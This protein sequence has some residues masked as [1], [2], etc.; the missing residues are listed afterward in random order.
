MSLQTFCR[1]VGHVATCRADM[2][3]HG[4]RCLLEICLR[5][6][7][8]CRVATCRRLSQLSSL[9]H[10]LKELWQGNNAYEQPKPR[11]KQK[12][13]EKRNKKPLKK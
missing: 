10:V 1:H 12:K 6:L 3:R 7:V 9:L 11:K 2:S 8:K 13:G 5:C 4:P